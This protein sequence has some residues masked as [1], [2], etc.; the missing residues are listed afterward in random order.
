MSRLPIALLLVFASSAS[1]SET[2]RIAIGPESERVSVT[3]SGLAW[4]NDD[5]DATF[6][7]IGVDTVEVRRAGD[8]I[9]VAGQTLPVRAIRF[10]SEGAL[11]VAGAHVRG[12]VVLV[13]GRR[14]L[15]AVNVLALEDY[16]TGVLGSE[17]P[18]SFPPEALKAQAIAARTYAYNKKLEQYGQPFH[19]GSSIISQVYKGLAAEDPRTRA[20]VEATKGLVLTFQLQPI[21]AYFHASCGGRTETGE[22]ALARPLPYLKSVDCPCHS[23]AASRWS[24]TISTSELKALGGHSM[25]VT[26][27]TETGRAKHV[28]IGSHALDAVRLRERIGYMKLK[29]LQFEVS[30]V[31]GGLKLEGHG[32][33]HGAGLCQWGARLLAEQG[34]TAESILFHYYP[35]TE[36]QQL[37]E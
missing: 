17:M 6:T 33:G 2:M 8:S 11:L 10:R 5:E 3:G 22:A 31:L 24:L 25:A 16:L 37:Y 21:E 28:S 30:P 35:G 27:R 34:L 4:A 23:V 12:D 15:V 26:G 7:A 18:R 1:A 20:A 14:G 32:F 13:R 19:L 36:L 29:S 9:E